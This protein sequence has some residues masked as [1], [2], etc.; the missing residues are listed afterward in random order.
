MKL[1]KALLYSLSLIFSSFS[2]FSFSLKGVVLDEKNEPLPFASIFIKSTSLG[3]TSNSQGEFLISLQPGKYEV[4]FRYLGYESVTK[5]IEIKNNDVVENITLKP[6]VILLADAVVGKSKEDPALT[7]MRKTIGMSVF[8]YKELLSFDYKTYLKGSLKVLEVPFLIKKAMEKEFF[9]KGQLYVFE[10]VGQV[11]FRAPNSF[12]QRIIGTKDNLPPNLKGNISFNAGKY[13]IYSPNNAISPVTRKGAKNYRYEYLGYFMDNEQVIN[14]IKVI[15]KNKLVGY[16]GVMNIVDDTWYIHSYDF[17]SIETESTNHTKAI[18]QPVDGIWFINNLNLNSKIDYMGLEL[19]MKAVVSYKDLKFKKDPRYA[20]V[21]PEIVDEKLFKEAADLPKASKVSKKVN[22]AQLKDIGKE[23]QKEDFQDLKKQNMAYVSKNTTYKVDSLAGKKDSLFWEAER[24]VPLTLVELKGFE[25]ADSIY[26]AN[27]DKINAKVK[28]D[29]LQ[30]VAPNKFK[31]KHLVGGNMYQYLKQSDTLSSYYKYQLR[32]I[33]LVKDTRFNAV[34]GYDIGL[35]GLA[36]RHNCTADKSF[37]V[38]LKPYYSISRNKLN[39]QVGAWVVLPNS[40]L[41][42]SVG[43]RVVHF[44]ENNPVNTLVNEVFALLG[45][46]HFAKFYEKNFVNMAYQIKPSPRWQFGTGASFT[47]RNL[48]DN[49]VNQGYI[50]NTSFFEPNNF[51]EFIGAKSGNSAVVKW[52]NTVAF[53]PK[54]MYAYYNGKKRIEKVFSPRFEMTNTFYFN[55]SFF[56][57]IELKGQQQFRIRSADLSARVNVG[58]FYGGGP[59]YFFDYKHFDGNLLWVNSHNSFRNLDYYAYSTNKSYAQY[60]L[61]LKPE[62]LLLSQ[63]V[64]LRKKGISEYLIHNYLKT[65]EISHIELGYGL[66]FL[67]RT[68]A[69]EVV[70][71]IN[72]RTYDKTSLRLTLPLSTRRFQ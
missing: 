53:S 58:T 19:E 50:K 21:K 56:G 41:S 49:I 54:A 55:D 4:V 69:V 6:S 66:G 25:Q 35:P 71:S 57:N 26:L 10:N 65:P 48:M 67:N 62:K 43:R 11:S 30:K 70:S 24:Q 20:S 38:D 23:L 3:T 18:F 16:S 37:N 63:F 22:L 39:G 27:F 44:N 36:F 33:S 13:E 64:A 60:F 47:Q 12:S 17:T 59:Q 29:S 46:Q 28:K 15:P 72:N 31:I 1:T 52:S 8:H 45:N 32:V 14:K 51:G 68:V 40:N 42:F 9:K 34:E 2:A 5:T 7:I 61:E